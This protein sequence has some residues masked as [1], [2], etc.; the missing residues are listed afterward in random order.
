MPAHKDIYHTGKILHR[1][2]SLANMM[3]HPDTGRG[4]LI[5]FDLCRFEGELAS[6]R[7]EPDRTVS[8][9]VPP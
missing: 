2:I 8:P 3:I 5:D 7:L 9:W 6:T 1:D 4:Y